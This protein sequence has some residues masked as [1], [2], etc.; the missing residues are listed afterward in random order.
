MR[1]RGLCCSPV[2]VRLSVRPSVWH[3]GALYPDDWDIVKLLSRPSSP[4]ILVTWL[5]SAGTQ[6]QGESLQQERKIH[7]VGKFCD[8]RLKSPFISETVRYEIGPWLIWNVGNHRWRIDTCR[9]RWPW[10]TLDPDFKV[11]TFFD[12]EY[13]RLVIENVTIRWRA[14]DFLLTLYSNYGSISCRLWDIQCRKISRPWNPGEGLIMVIDS[15]I[16]W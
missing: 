6:F 13:L 2:S 10:V 12:I 4:I 7:G 9:F 3:V 11:T 1:K 5:P 8:F 16:I 15:G 14:Y